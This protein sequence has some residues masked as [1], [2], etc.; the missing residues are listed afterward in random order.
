MILLYLHKFFMP[1]ASRDMLNVRT[2]DRRD[3]LIED[4]IRLRQLF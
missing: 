3:D 4:R 1:L 2:L